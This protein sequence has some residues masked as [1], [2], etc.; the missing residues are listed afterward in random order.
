MTDGSTTLRTNPSLSERTR[1]PP[2]AHSTQRIHCRHPQCQKSLQ[3][4]TAALY[5]V[6]VTWRREFKLCSVHVGCVLVVTAICG[7]LQHTTEFHLF[8][9]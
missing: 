7:H 8:Q 2:G 1:G 3:R 6:D 4:F 5:V 9:G